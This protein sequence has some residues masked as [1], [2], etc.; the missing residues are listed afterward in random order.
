[1]TFRRENRRVFQDQEVNRYIGMQNCSGS[2]TCSDCEKLRLAE[3]AEEKVEEVMVEEAAV[4]V[5]LALFGHRTQM[6]W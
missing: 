4:E 3:E 1:M 2:E 6:R 5:E